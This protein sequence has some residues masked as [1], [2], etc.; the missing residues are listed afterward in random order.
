MLSTDTSV[1]TSRYVQAIQWAF[2][3]HY[4]QVRHNTETPYISHLLSTS[5]LVIEEGAEEDTAIA[6]LL[7]DVLE[8]QP[9]SVAEVEH[10]FGQRV[11]QI[12]S[13]CT[14]AT[15]MERESSSW[16]ERKEAHLVR[17]RGFDPETLLVMLA[18]KIS[19]L[20][21]LVD[22]LRRYGPGFFAGSA[23]KAE[24]LLWHYREANKVFRAKLN[25]VALLERFSVLISDATKLA[26]LDGDL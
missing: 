16:R 22:D 6:A 26:G 14:D 1:L 13:A 4:L 21:A 7:H 20:Q 12:V 10:S 19:S 24:E 17:M 15:L 23:Q 3:K 11:A 8:D 2:E 9:V 5:A 18:D 25:R